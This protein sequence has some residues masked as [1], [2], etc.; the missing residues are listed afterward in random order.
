MITVEKLCE[1]LTKER[2]EV[3]Q[4]REYLDLRLLVIP[5]FVCDDGTHISIQASYFHY[6]DKKQDEND[7][8][9]TDTVVDAS[10]YATFEICMNSEEIKTN[11]LRKMDKD[12]MDSVI[13]YVPIDLIV[14]E[15]NAHQFQQIISLN[16]TLLAS[17]LSLL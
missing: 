12:C 1:W 15:I 7:E 3:A 16:L 9:N 6:C 2:T 17:S 5:P 10:A 8:T 11:S 4:Q 14:A 13:G